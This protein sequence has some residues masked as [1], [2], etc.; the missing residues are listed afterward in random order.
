MLALI[1]AL[2]GIPGKLEVE[3][4]V[5]F[6]LSISVITAKDIGHKKLV[7]LTINA[8]LGH[9]GN[10]VLS[11]EKTALL[12]WRYQNCWKLQYLLACA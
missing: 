7:L 1:V 4:L 5:V 8:Q 11:T 3:G 10:Q 9:R 12:T 2:S 6:G